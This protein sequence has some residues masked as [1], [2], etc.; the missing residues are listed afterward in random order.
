MRR[1]RT[2]PVV[3]IGDLAAGK[4]ISLATYKR[5]GTRVATPVWVTGEGD[6]LYVITDA[7]SGKAKR[8]R[9]S[10][11]AQ[12]APCDMRG[13]V[14]GEVADVTA[15]LLDAQG[16]Q[17]VVDRINAKYGL[18]ARLFGLRGTVASWRGKP[19]AQVGIEITLA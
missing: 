6:H 19:S 15:V 2:I 5:D 8:L 14:T 1:D 10:P 18:V 4:Y 3:T 9:N 11:K 16:T 17:E 13:T 12:V 7:D